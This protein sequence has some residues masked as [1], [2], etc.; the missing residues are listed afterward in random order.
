MKKV[1]DL[2]DDIGLPADITETL[3]IMKRDI[4]DSKE[5]R[6]RIEN[7]Y[8]DIIDYPNGED[9]E[10]IRSFLYEFG[11]ML[12]FLF[13]GTYK[14][15][16]VAAWKKAVEMAAEEGITG[17]AVDKA[18]GGRAGKNTISYYEE[19]IKKYE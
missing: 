7:L 3:Q 5:R 16:A 1:K 8:R 6:I 13:K 10:S 2:A 11:N 17:D 9:K 14:D 18:T 15:M 12:T 4:R 19:K